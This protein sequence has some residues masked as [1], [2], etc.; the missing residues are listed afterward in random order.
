MSSSIT[1]VCWIAVTAA[2]AAAA[3]KVDEDC[4]L[5]GICSTTTASCKCNPGWKGDTCALLNRKLVSNSIQSHH[6]F[7]HLIFWDTLAFAR[8]PCTPHNTLYVDCGNT[9]YPHT[10]C[11]QMICF[12]AF[13]RTGTMHTHNTLY[14]DC[15]IFIPSTDPSLRVRWQPSTGC[16]QTLLRGVAT[17]WWTTQPGC[18]T[19]T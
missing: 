9:I 15:W 18:I 2:A 7:H 3:C 19:S 8:A 17:C 14:V 10:Y 16:I 6:P 4:S 11:L 12:L 5:N 1:L 13:N